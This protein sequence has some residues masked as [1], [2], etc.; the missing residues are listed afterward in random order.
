MKMSEKVILG[1]VENVIKIRSDE[2]NKLG[3]ATINNRL[4]Q[5]QIKK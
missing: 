5:R 1:K 2:V 3:N 4:I